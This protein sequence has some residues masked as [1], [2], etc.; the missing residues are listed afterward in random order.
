MSSM[1]GKVA[2][3]TGASRGVGKG[4][5]IGLG[6]A[7]ATVYVTGRTM[8][9][10]EARVPIP[11]SLRATVEE[12][13]A[14][15]GTGIAARVDHRDDDQ[16]AS[17]FRRVEEEQGRLDVLVNSAW[18]GYDSLHTMKGPDDY[19]FE[20]PF[21][22]LPMSIYDDMDAVG[23]RSAY[24]ASRLATPLIISSGGGL[25]AHISSF[26]GKQF[27]Y[28]VPYGVAKAAVDRMA[29]DMAHDLRDHWVACVSLYPGLVRTEAIMRNADL[30][31][32]S[33]SESP[34]FTGRAVVALAT[35]PDVMARTGQVLV[36][37][38]T[39][40]RRDRSYTWPSPSWV[41]W[42]RG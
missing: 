30:F 12:V 11:S 1:K 6:E 18:A 35:D 40:S 20:L 41:S 25:I 28:N 16:V 13:E 29:S 33:N 26:A 10:E 39:S 19:I 42:V 38:S 5:A 9:Q 4:V 23:Q 21:W 2:V 8:E 24:V 3:V 7:G 17:L 22:E 37:R 34:T 14:V 36:V 27:L 31:D 32:L 15:G